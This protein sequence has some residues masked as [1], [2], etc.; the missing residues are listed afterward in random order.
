ML[1]FFSIECVAEYVIIVAAS[2]V[3]ALIRCTRVQTLSILSPS[4]IVYSVRRTKRPRYNCYSC[5]CTKNL[6]AKPTNIHTLSRHTINTLLNVQMYEARATHTKNGIPTDCCC[7]CVFHAHRLAE[8][9][10]KA[11]RQAV[12]RH[13]FVPEALGARMRSARHNTFAI[14]Y[15]LPAQAHIMYTWRTS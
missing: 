9:I 2:I 12:S 5:S 10:R 6:R 14:C 3:Y 7:E 4:R 11:G 13:T 15:R 1:W 8:R